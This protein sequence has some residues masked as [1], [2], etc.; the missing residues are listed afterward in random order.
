MA[1]GYTVKW[2]ERSGTHTEIT[3]SDCPD[4]ETAK[5]EA[6]AS[7][8]ESGWTP[9]K[10]W[11]WWRWDENAQQSVHLTAERRWQALAIFYWLVS[12]AVAAYCIGVR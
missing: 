12:L 7:A 3:V 9:R 11:Q 5:R 10:W 4:M 6:F 2:N 8:K 1:Y